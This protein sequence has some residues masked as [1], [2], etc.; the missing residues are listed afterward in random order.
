ME[1]YT[2]EREYCGVTYRMRFRED[3][4]EEAANWIWHLGHIEG[5]WP[6]LTPLDVAHLGADL[7]AI[8]KKL[9][10]EQDLT[11][12]DAKLSMGFPVLLFVGAMGLLAMMMGAVR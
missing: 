6:G 9:N 5:R 12:P 10:P 7:E 8:Y 4:I 2:V 3:R 11:P 1:V